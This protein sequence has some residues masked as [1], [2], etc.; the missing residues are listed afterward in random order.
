MSAGKSLCAVVVFVFA[1]DKKSAPP[2]T[3]ASGSPVAAPIVDAAVV[4]IADAGVDATAPDAAPVECTAQA[5]GA[6]RKA[7]EAEVKAGKYDAAIALLATEGCYLDAD[8]PASLQKA[9]AWR[10]SDLSFAYYKAGR[11]GDCY[12]IASAQV[13]PYIGNVG[14]V[15]DES[16]P[17][18]KALEHNAGLCQDA[19]V[20]ERG[21]FADSESCTLAENGYAVPASALDKTDKAACLVLGERKKDED[22]LVVCGDVTL[23]RQS[24]AG[25]LAR[26]KLAVSGGNLT[27]G[28]VCCNIESVGFG[29]H[30]ANLAI[31]VQTMGRNCDGGTASTEEQHAYEVK[32]SALELYHS[33]SAA[34]H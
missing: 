29:R 28:G 11:F 32:G 12:A 31:L 4:A 18:M 20:K 33:L 25:K 27:D 16:D 9:I 19:A 5:I 26:T 23:V 7:A 15:F 2:P 34:A 8:Q 10:L 30:G 24:K 14:S 13:S 1:C 6:V 3:P 21:S 22:E 17:V